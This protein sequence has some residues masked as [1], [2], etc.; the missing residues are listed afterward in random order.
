MKVM[1]LE[2]FMQAGEMKRQFEDQNMLRLLAYT[3]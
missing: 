1:S 3:I 2:P